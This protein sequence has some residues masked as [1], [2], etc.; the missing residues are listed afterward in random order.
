MLGR[1]SPRW[2]R[3]HS[4]HLLSVGS[5]K[6]PRQWTAAIIHQ[7]FLL[8]WRQCWCPSFG[9]ARRIGCKYIS[10]NCIGTHRND[11]TH[12]SLPVR[13]SQHTQW[14]LRCPQAAVASLRHPW[15]ESLRNRSSTS[16]TL[17]LGS[18]FHKELTGISPAES[19]G[20]PIHIPTLSHLFSYP[21]SYSEKVFLQLQVIIEN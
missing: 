10:R 18:S 14:M 15:K 3:V 13:K 21:M 4:N 2:Q 8:S 1:W 12:S 5:K 9:K 17:F 16:R 6:S 19:L 11:I 7:L 20:F